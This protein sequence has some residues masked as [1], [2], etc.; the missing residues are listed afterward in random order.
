MGRA[1]RDRIL[2][3]ILFGCGVGCGGGTM[4]VQPGPIG[5]VNHTQHSDAD[6][7]AIWKAA[8]QS[9]AAQIDL[10]PVQQ[11]VSGAA[12]DMLPGDSRALTVQPHQLLVASEPDVASS[13]LFSA[14][15]V[16][17]ADPTGLIACPQPCDVR[18]APAYS[19]Y[20]QP[21]T[22]YAASWELQDS[23]FDSILQYEF[24]N[25]I[26]NALGYDMQWR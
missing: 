22:K 6:L 5:F 24:E 14:T 17:R 10:N 3:L 25:H 2:L 16:L 9:L 20:A 15:G 12:P 8:Q 4:G 19:S 23:G 26:L 1:A 7:S 21:V 11:T 13:T 18:Y